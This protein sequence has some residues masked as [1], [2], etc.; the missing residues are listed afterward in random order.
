[1]PKVKKGKSSRQ[2]REERKQRYNA[3]KITLSNLIEALATT[4]ITSFSCRVRM[5]ILHLDMFRTLTHLIFLMKMVPALQKYLALNVVTK[6]ATKQQDKK[7][8]RRISERERYH[9]KKQYQNKMLQAK[10]RRYDEDE[11][12]KEKKKSTSMD[13]YH[14]NEP[15][16]RKEESYQYG[17]VS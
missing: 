10:K 8:K 14:N 5:M 4:E 1:M 9:G 11:A 17:H 13:M 3:T 6:Q 15:Y 7:L 12:Y 2:K 16:M